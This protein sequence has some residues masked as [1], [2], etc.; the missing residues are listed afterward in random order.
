MARYFVFTYGCKIMFLYTKQSVSY[1]MLQSAIF[2][3]CKKKKKNNEKPSVD[4]FFE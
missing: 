2:I 4:E 3:F 1:T